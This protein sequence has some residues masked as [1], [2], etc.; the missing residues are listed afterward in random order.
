VG[1]E[2]YLLLITYLGNRWGWVV[3]T[4]LGHA[5]R[6]PVDRRLGGPQSRS[7]HR[8]YRKNS[9]PVP[10][11]DSRWS[12]L[13]SDTILTELPRFIAE[14]LRRYD[15][16]LR[17]VLKNLLIDSILG[18]RGSSDNSVCLRTGRPGDRGS[19]PGRVKR[20]DWLLGLPSLLYNGYRGSFHQE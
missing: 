8:S 3:S 9:S 17:T 4:T 6:Y 12:S 19:I 18:S 2:E 15:F 5:L 11:I 20:R 13:Y 7:G 16:I 14:Q 10:E 1:P